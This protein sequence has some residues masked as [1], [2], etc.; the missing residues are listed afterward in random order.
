MKAIHDALVKL[1][2]EAPLAK[3]DNIAINVLY[4]FSKAVI[5]D[6]AD[7]IRHKVS[8][9]IR[10]HAGENELEEIED[11]GPIVTIAQVLE[12]DRAARE[13]EILVTLVLEQ[14]I[15]SAEHPM[16]QNSKRF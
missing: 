1:S 4:S 14:Q 10:I 15:V 2:D 3:H 7:K 8:P 5:V 16:T 13:D 6:T 9:D 12:E 11:T